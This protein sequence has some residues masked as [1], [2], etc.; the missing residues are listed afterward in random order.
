MNVRKNSKISSIEQKRLLFLGLRSELSYT[1]RSDF[2]LT[3]VKN[4]N[5]LESVKNSGLEGD[6]SPPFD[7][8]SIPSARTTYDNSRV[9]TDSFQ[10]SLSILKEKPSPSPTSD[11]PANRK[12]LLKRRKPHRTGTGG[13]T[14]MTNIVNTSVSY[15]SQ[16]SLPDGEDVSQDAFSMFRKQIAMKRKENSKYK[17]ISDLGMD[18]EKILEEVD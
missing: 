16:K 4:V 13:G 11:A 5:Q 1:L 6:R 7:T 8:L 2:D 3:S 9:Y 12:K 18:E 10:K 14:S 17:T 15:W